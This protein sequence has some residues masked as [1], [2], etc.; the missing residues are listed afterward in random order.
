VGAIED[1]LAQLGITGA[2]GGQGQGLGL[3]GPNA[4][5]LPG[6]YMGKTSGPAKKQFAPGET[7]PGA[8]GGPSGGGQDQ[9]L[10]IAQAQ[11]QPSHWTDQEKN[12]FINS[13]VMRK[14]PGFSQNMGLPDIMNK[15]DDM[16]QLSANLGKQ[17]IQMSPMDIMNTYK[18]RE[19]Q[20]YKKG[21]WEYDAVTDQPVKYVGPTSRTDTST[22][23]DLSTREDALA[24]AK[25]S[26]AQM[27]GRAPTTNELSSY[28]G[29]LNGYERA[30]PTQSMTTTNISAE[31]G[32]QTSSNT[33][34]SGGVTQAGR[35]AV[36]EQN[37]QQNP[38]Y[39]NYQASTT[40]YNAMMQQLMR[41]Y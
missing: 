9:Y 5:G 10:S 22:R 29:L 25:T 23:L 32:E 15:W 2:L 14:I 16:V 21:N 30:N 31:T 7:T 24:L 1:Q 20:T 41:G 19:G 17:G 26:M 3:P 27:L 8:I 37:M 12:D 35:S 6:V 38:E 28:L 36:L 33:Q 39:A 11:V 4:L 34:S 40:Y 13:W 18:S